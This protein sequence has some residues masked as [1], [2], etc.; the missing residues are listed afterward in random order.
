MKIFF[1]M[2]FAVLVVLGCATN[3]NPNPPEIDGRLTVAGR[4]DIWAPS[5]LEKR[6]AITNGWKVL[7]AVLS[8]DANSKRSIRAL[9]GSQVVFAGDG[10]RADS[11]ANL[12]LVSN[13]VLEV[14]I[15]P[16]HLSHPQNF[17]WSAEVFGT[18]KEVDFDKRVIR[19][20]AEPENWIV[21][22]G[23]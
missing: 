9:Y 1:M 2:L 15:S 17:S 18:V 4:T 16:G 13:V 20:V 3:P 19:I 12:D 22:A 8:G 14:E 21:A 10:P 6:T 23:L 5:F 7:N 11:Y